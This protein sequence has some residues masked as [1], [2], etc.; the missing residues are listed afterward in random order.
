MVSPSNVSP[1]ASGMSCVS[2]SFE[3]LYCFFEEIVGLYGY[4]DDE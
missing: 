1:D 2:I 3:D 4:E